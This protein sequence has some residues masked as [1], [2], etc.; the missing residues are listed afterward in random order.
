[1]SCIQ[2]CLAFGTY[3]YIKQGNRILVLDAIRGRNLASLQVLGMQ[4]ARVLVS[5]LR[6]SSNSVHVRSSILTPAFSAVVHFVPPS[7]DASSFNLSEIPS[8]SFNV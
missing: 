8:I 7:M 6:A 4:H 5:C 1:M 2:L 3:R